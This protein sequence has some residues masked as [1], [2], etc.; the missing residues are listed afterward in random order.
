MRGK[1]L[2]AVLTASVLIFATL[3]S[4]RALSEA[5]VANPM[6][7]QT[8]RV[9]TA[10]AQTLTR[11]ALLNAS[12][13]PTR[14]RTATATSTQSD[15]DFLTE[16][17]ATVAAFVTPTSPF[18]QTETTIA[19]TISAIESIPTQTVTPTASSTP[20]LVATQTALAQ[21]LVFLQTRTPVRRTSCLW[22]RDWELQSDGSFLWIGSPPGSVGCPRVGQAGDLLSRMGNRERLT[23]IVEIG[24]TPLP[25]SICFYDFV[26]ITADELI[27]GHSEGYPCTDVVRDNER[28]Q[29]AGTLIVTGSTGF[30]IGHNTP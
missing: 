9:G 21:T 17:A 8:D 5:N 7:Q 20:P 15:A 30:M 18:W 25:I 10:V 13:T 27:D 23:L 6:Y 14:T 29:V 24:D 11:Q 3:I 16:V 26:E 12:V 22:A 1:L 28:P 4:S 2:F 19:Q